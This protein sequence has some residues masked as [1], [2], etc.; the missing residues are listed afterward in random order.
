[1]ITPVKD[2]LQAHAGYGRIVRFQSARYLQDILDIVRCY[3][4]N[5]NGIS[6]AIPQSIPRDQWGSIPIRSVSICA[7]SG[8]SLLSGTDVDLLLTGEMSHHEA[9][10]AIE[11][12]RCVMTTFH[13]NTER[14]FLAKR[15]KKDLVSLIEKEI[16]DLRR[17]GE[18]DTSNPSFEVAVSETDRDPFEIVSRS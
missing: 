8:G 10:A 15:M 14:A 11:Q 9:L 6:L 17:R 16:S 13:S 4:G 3:L 18:W 12:G 2:P 7:G 5:L 1:V